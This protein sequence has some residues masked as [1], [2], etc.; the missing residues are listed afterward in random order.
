MFWVAVINAD[1]GCKFKRRSAHGEALEEERFWPQ[2]KTSEAEEVRSGGGAPGG[3]TERPEQSMF[4]E[5]V[6][7][8]EREGPAEQKRP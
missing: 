8:Q 1:F 3:R 6:G 4:S 2:E 7:Q 5:R